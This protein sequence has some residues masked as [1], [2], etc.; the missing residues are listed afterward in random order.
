MNIFVFDTKFIIEPKRTLSDLKFFGLYSKVLLLLKKSWN[1]S[2]SFCFVPKIFEK[3]ET[4]FFCKKEVGTH[5]KVLVLF[6]NFWNKQK[7]ST[8]ASGTHQNV[9]VSF[10]F[11]A[12][13]SERLCFSFLSV[14]GSGSESFYETVAEEWV[15]N[16]LTASTTLSQPWEST[17]EFPITSQLRLVDC[18]GLENAL[19]AVRVSAEAVIVHSHG[20]NWHSQGPLQ[21]S[22]GL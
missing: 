8:L 4:F 14:S 1:T 16:T 5:Q 19:E 3:I 6:Q 22:H 13:I 9:L 2:K 17:C 11:L 12:S 10:R 7:R 15:Y 20:L 21:V 18:R